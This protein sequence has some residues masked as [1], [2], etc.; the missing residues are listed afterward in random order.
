MSKNMLEKIPVK[1]L[2]G[3]LLITAKRIQRNIYY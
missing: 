2:D 3:A 1:K